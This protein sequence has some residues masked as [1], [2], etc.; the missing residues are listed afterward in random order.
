M[1]IVPISN[2]QSQ[3]KARLPLVEMN[4]LV[5][6]ALSHDK[7]AG[8]PKLYTLLEGLDNMPGIK[9]EMKSWVRNNQSC[10]VGFSPDRFL[11]QCQLRIDG[12]LIEEGKDIFSTLYRAV[13][14]TKTKD[15]RKINM[16]GAVFDIMWWENRD[17]T[18]DD[19]KGLL[20]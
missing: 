6:S 3:F 2:N 10:I 12:V 1:K 5:D 9:A 15:G 13:T 7:N 20:I 8:I 11:S 4:T 17:K 19:I 14:S 16:P 18:V